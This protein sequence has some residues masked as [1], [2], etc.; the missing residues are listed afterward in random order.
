MGDGLRKMSLRDP[1]DL[2]EVPRCARND[3]QSEGGKRA[4]DACDDL[5]SSEN[6]KQVIQTWPNI[7]ASHGESRGMHNSADFY[8]EFCSYALQC[9]FNCSDIEFLQR[10]QSVANG[11]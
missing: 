5:F 11:L 4:I 6:F 9:G 3:G 10:A 7:A 1:L 2:W 8:A